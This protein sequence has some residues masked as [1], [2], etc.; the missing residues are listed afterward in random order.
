[1]KLD[2]DNAEKLSD[3]V[4]RTLTE[5]KNQ[6]ILAAVKSVDISDLKNIRMTLVTDTLVNM[7]EDGE[8]DGNNIEYKIA[9]LKAILAEMPDSQ[10]GGVIELAD[11]ENVT[12]RMS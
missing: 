3:L 7:G 1:M 11:T 12:S 5:L 2:S 4:V 9:Y 8:E 10:K 6:S